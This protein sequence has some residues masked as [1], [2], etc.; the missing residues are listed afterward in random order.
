MV[1]RV[2]LK[3]VRKSS[4]QPLPPADLD[5]RSLPLEKISRGRVYKRLHPYDADAVYFNKTNDYRFNAPNE[6][7]GVLYVAEELKGAFAE[8]LLRHPG[9][10]LIDQRDIDAK[11]VSEIKIRSQLNLVKLFGHGLVRVGATAT[12]SS[13]DYAISQAWSLAL[14]RHPQKPDGIIYRANHDNDQICLAL[15]EHTRKHV[16][17]VKTV[18]LGSEPFLAEL[19]DHYGVGIG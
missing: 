7:Y 19:F 6:Q 3:T 1:S 13:G 10:T 2:P 9:K 8:T 18:P 4:Q 5:S 17:M 15:Y 14:W 12:V 11:A 16:R